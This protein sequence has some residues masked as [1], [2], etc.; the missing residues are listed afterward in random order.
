M[1]REKRT[2]SELKGKEKKCITTE[3]NLEELLSENVQK[4]KFTC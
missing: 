3:K 4:G 2:G 1:K